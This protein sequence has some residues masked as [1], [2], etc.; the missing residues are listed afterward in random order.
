M[1]PRIAFKRLAE[2]NGK[3]PIEPWEPTLLKV[4]PEECANCLLGPN[5][6][7][8]EESIQQHLDQC[9]EMVFQCHLSTIAGKPR[10][11]YQFF[12]QQI[13]LVAR[14]AKQYGW[15]VYEGIGTRNV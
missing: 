10:C 4:M 13:S 5:P 6:L 3:L 11:C 15:Y 7:V 8:D 2:T 14:L 9:A 12:E 1:D